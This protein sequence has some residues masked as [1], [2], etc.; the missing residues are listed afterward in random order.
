MYDASGEMSYAVEYTLIEVSSG[1]YLYSA[2]SA[3]NAEAS[4]EA[5][6]ETQN[7]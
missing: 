5:V 2:V 1:R 4:L 7:S 3:A 6:V